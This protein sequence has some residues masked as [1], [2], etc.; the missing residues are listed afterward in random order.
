MKND[1]LIQK[2][3]IGFDVIKSVEK[4][5]LE[6]K[7]GTPQCA[8][9]VRTWRGLKRR[10]L[11]F[12]LVQEGPLEKR[13]NECNAVIQEWASGKAQELQNSWADVSCT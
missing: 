4:L 9:I 7:S 11:Q 5:H 12:A 3:Q 10:F 8:E 6:G 2:S 13:R 1:E